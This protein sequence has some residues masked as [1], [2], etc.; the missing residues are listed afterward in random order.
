MKRNKQS[1]HNCQRA[2]VYKSAPSVCLSVS[3]S[4]ICHHSHGWKR[5]VSFGDMNYFL[6]FLVQYSVQTVN[7][8]YEPTMEFH[9][10][11]KNCALLLTKTVMLF[12]MGGG[13]GPCQN[14]ISISNISSSPQLHSEKF[15]M[16]RMAIS[17]WVRIYVICLVSEMYLLFSF[18]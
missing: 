6:P 9:K 17:F 16:N 10:W 12:L 4:I 2:T 18:R 15:K 14:H 3:V 11:L 7:D 5:E 1:F 13:L 8:P